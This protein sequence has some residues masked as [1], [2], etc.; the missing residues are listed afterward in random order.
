M[1]DSFFSNARA[2]SQ[3]N[4]LLGK[5]RLYRMIDCETAEEAYKILLESGF[6]NGTAGSCASSARTNVAPVSNRKEKMGIKCIVFT[7]RILPRP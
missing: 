5:D 2:V 4:Y 7:M 3:E 1:V 6:G